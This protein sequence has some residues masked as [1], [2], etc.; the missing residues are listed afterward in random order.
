MKTI[1]ATVYFWED[2]A[3]AFFFAFFLFAFFLFAFFSSSSKSYSLAFL[4][5]R[6]GGK[7]RRR[8]RKKDEAKPSSS[9][10][11]TVTYKS[12]SSPKIFRNTA[13]PPF[14]QRNISKQ[15]II[16]CLPL[17]LLAGNHFHTGSTSL[18]PPFGNER[19]LLPPCPLGQSG[20]A[21]RLQ[22][23]PWTLSARERSAQIVGRAFPS[24][25]VFCLSWDVDKIERNKNQLALKLLR[26]RTYSPPPRTYS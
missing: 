7:G 1:L 26:V 21:P 11:C 6:G 20:S 2:E 5:K 19:S 4:A 14:W 15:E 3:K 12:E 24:P 9:Q 10:K 22:A 18:P 25:P 8:R 17:P 23:R 13:P 16:L